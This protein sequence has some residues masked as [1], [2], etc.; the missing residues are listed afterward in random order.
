MFAQFPTLSMPPILAQT[1]YQWMKGL[2]Y[3]VTITLPRII[4]LHS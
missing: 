1:N 2:I 3:Q 4:D